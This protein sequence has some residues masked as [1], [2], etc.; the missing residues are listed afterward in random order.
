MEVGNVFDTAHAAMM[1]DEMKVNVV[2]HK[3]ANPHISDTSLAENIVD[4]MVSQRSFEANAH[5]IKTADEMLDGI[6]TM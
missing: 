3:I 6:F 2:A 1:R 5:V 4:M